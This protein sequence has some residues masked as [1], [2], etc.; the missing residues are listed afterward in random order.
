[1]RKEK[2]PVFQIVGYKNAGKTTLI[3]SLIKK[4]QANGLKVGTIKH[5]GHGGKPDRVQGTDTDKQ[6]AA[7]AAC[8]AVLGEQEWQL[9]IGE[10]A[11]PSLTKMVELYAQFGVDLILI[12][13][14]KQARYPKIVLLRDNSDVK[15]LDLD[16][17]IAVGGWAEPLID[18]AIYT[19]ALNNFPQYEKALVELLNGR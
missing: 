2:I 9:L 12:E 18:K 19:F 13:G 15:L 5:H 16:N 1:M 8:A 4:M 14:F 3:T 10:E 11:A 17:V 7:G 6:M